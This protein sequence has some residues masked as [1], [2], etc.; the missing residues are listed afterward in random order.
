MSEQIIQ[1]KIGGVTPGRAKATWVC[2]SL[3]FP[4]A[5]SDNENGGELCFLPIW[6]FKCT[7]TW[8]L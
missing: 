5:R 4:D 1:C 6:L 2:R 8:T 7:C 3:G